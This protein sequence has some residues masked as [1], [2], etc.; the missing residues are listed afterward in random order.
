MCQQVFLRFALGLAVDGFR[1]TGCFFRKPTVHPIGTGL[2]AADKNKGFGS[3]IFQKAIVQLA[4]KLVIGLPVFLFIGSL[5][6]IVRFSCQVDVMAKRK[7][8]F[9]PEVSIGQA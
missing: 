5:L 9:L 8:G 6:Q 2:D 7:V 3:G 1:S 4:G